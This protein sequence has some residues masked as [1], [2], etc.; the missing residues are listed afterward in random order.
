MPLAKTAE[1]T[2]AKEA[3]VHST[4]DSLMPQEQRIP[5]E[6]YR[7]F[8][9]TAERDSGNDKLKTVTSWAY[10][11][12]KTTGEA[13][14][15][16]RNLE[17]KLGQSSVGETRLDKLANWVRVSNSIASANLSM[18]Q[19]L[20][21]IKLKHKTQLAEIRTNHNERLGKIN[22][23]I[24]RIQAENRKVYTTA[25]SRTKLEMDRIKN[26]YENQLKELHTLRQA[27]GGKK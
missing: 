4:P 17:L 15:Q 25:R 16:I 6:V 23:E 7:F 20:E 1:Q 10:K 2:V 11:D 24:A 3:P 21:G 13:L 5:T 8:N 12:G 14:K 18:K 26:E 19:E 9:L 27:Y 22:N